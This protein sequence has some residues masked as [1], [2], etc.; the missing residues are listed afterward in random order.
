M[1][2]KTKGLFFACALGISTW[3]Q[4]QA[5]SLY[6]PNKSFKLDF[7]I[8]NSGIPSYEL[9]YKNKEIIKPSQLGFAL[10]KGEGLDSNFVVVKTDYSEKDTIWHP[11][12]GE[13]N[14]VREHYKEMNVHLQ[15]TTT[16]RLMTVCFRLFDDGLGFRYIFPNQKNLQYFVI[17]EEKTQFAINGDATAFWKPGDYDTEEYQTVKSP[18]SQVRALLPGDARENASQTIFSPTGVQTPLLLQTPDKVWMNIHE[19]ELVNYPAL[20]LELNDKNYI[21]NAHLTPDAAGNKGFMQ[22]PTHTPWRTIIASDQAKDILLSHLIENLNPPTQYKD[23]S[24]IKPMKYMGVWWEMITNKST[25][26]YSDTTNIELNTA[27]YSKMKPNGKH[28]ANTENVKK[29]IDFAAANGIHALLVEGWNV[30]WEDWF[31]HMKDYVFDFVTPYPDFDVNAL[32][33]YGKEKGVQLIMHNETSGSIRNYERHL[34]TALNFMNAHNY[35]AVKTGYVGDMLPI[36][37]HHYSQWIVN[38][39]QHV[40]DE[41]AKHHIMVDAHE[42]VHM[43]GLSRTYPN[44]L[45][46]ES[47]CGT[48]YESFGGNNPDHTT[49]LPFTRLKGGAMDYTPGIFEMNLSSFSPSNNSHVNSTLARQLALYVVMYSPFQMAADMPEHYQAHMDAFQF[50]KDVPVDWDDTKVLE[51]APGDCITYARKEKGKDNWFVGSSVDENG[52]L[53]NLSFDFL[54]KGKKYIATIYKDAKDANYKTNPQA[55]VIEKKVVDSKTKLNIQSAPGGGFA[56]SLFE[57]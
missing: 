12:Y 6:S 30:G 19:A 25:W 47:D 37:E 20:N 41:A 52:H 18:L 49:I 21:L 42:A 8:E 4:L 24:W 23:V 56:I 11:I 7:H 45:A 31:G 36:G 40:V 50:I 55:Y 54:P 48:E 29:Y 51:A 28:A 13:V 14:Q 9:N 2:L 34:D 33:A 44:L 57:K 32:E 46:Q 27:D 10:T 53:S 17:K 16:G 3:G 1:Y 15:Q 38:H 39:Y 5:Q 35:P 22:A 43:T 26:A